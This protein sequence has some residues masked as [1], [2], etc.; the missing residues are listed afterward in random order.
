VWGFCRLSTSTVVVSTG[1]DLLLPENISHLCYSLLEC[2]C[3]VNTPLSLSSKMSDHESRSAAPAPPPKDD[4]EHMI[5]PSCVIQ[6]GRAVATHMEQMMEQQQLRLRENPGLISPS[7]DE[8]IAESRPSLSSNRNHEDEDG[9]EK[10]PAA[11][12]LRFSS[13]VTEHGPSGGWELE[14]MLPMWWTRSEIET[15]HKAAKVKARSFLRRSDTF[16][17]TF[18]AVF[19]EC[20]RDRTGR[21]LLESESVQ[22]LL[23]S[24]TTLR[25]LESRTI[26]IIRE[27]RN[28]HARSVLEVATTNQNVDAALRSR[29]LQTSRP[30]KTLARI[31]AKQDS[32]AIAH[33]I[34]KELDGE[35]PSPSSSSE[36]TESSDHDAA[37]SS[38]SVP[39]SPRPSSDE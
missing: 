28:F 22:R 7:F 12:A 37:A 19:Q 17:K 27:Y 31:L 36:D 35:P 24:A 15:F 4:D 18:Q 34:R 5:S 20:S 39:S 16:K 9:D 30:S 33:M 32:I 21:N 3:P 1:E 2:M 6:E 13:N 26:G 11:K 25:G 14:D 8:E 38:F 23:S 29:S 10:M